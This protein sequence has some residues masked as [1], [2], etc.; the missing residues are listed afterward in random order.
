MKPRMFSP[1]STELLEAFR[2]IPKIN[3]SALCRPKDLLV[4]FSKER[5]GLWQA[6]DAAREQWK[7]KY[8]VPAWTFSPQACDMWSFFDHIQPDDRHPDDTFAALAAHFLYSWRATQG[9]YRLHETLFNALQTTELSGAVPCEV[10]KRIPEWCL[11]VET[12]AM[13]FVSASG[14]ADIAHGFFMLLDPD[15]ETGEPWVAFF[16]D[17]SSSYEMAT[18][19]LVD[20]MNIGQCIEET[21]RIVSKRSGRNPK[22]EGIEPSAAAKD[23]VDLL[24]PF[25]NIALFIC[26]QASEISDIHGK[27]PS[28]PEEKKTKRGSRV[29]PPNS[30]RE[31]GVGFR[32][33]AALKLADEST[34]H[35][36]GIG[37]NGVRPHIRR[38]HWHGFWHGPRD[39][40]RHFKLKWLPPVAVKVDSVDSLP[41]VARA[42]A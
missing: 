35:D 9:V 17:G 15:R 42:V 6:M 39:G 1:A 20:G 4:N 11:Y 34:N 10:L 41:A 37:F 40:E 16:I 24:T 21:I 12:P 29:F 14:S 28:L 19:K 26:S 5:P 32:I 33:G 31:W 30:P 23:M 7:N 36:D 25:L 2:L 38:A 3:E 18:M 22:H 13:P 27:Q 8:R